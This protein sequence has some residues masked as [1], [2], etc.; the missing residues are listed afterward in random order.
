MPRL[1]AF[2]ELGRNQGASDVHL[3]VG[4]PPMVRVL[5]AMKPVKYR[6]LDRDELESLVDEILTDE[7]RRIFSDG[8][9]IDFSYA[10]PDVGRFRANVY[11]KLSGVGATF[12]VIPHQM[13]T[14]DDLGHPPVLKRLTEHSHGM[15]LVTGATGTGKTTTLAAMIN[16]MN[17]T[18]R[19]NIITLEDPVEFLH[20]SKQSL[21]VQREIGTSAASFQ[22][23]LRAA[24][25][26]DPDVILVGELRDPETIS[27]AMTAAETGH[28]VL[29][30]LH[31]TTATKTID[32]IIDVMPTEMK[33][34]AQVFLSQHLRGVVSQRL[35]RTA[36]KNSRRAVLEIMLN[37]PAIGNLIL[38]G[39]VFQIPSQIQTGRDKGMQLMDQTLMQAIL[40][41]ELDPDDAYLN[42]DDK[43]QFQRFVTDPDLLPQVSL[44]GV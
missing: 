38:N 32:R 36:D 22:D 40:N 8:N 1:N 5:G 25:R 12:R 6:A 23:G 28:L 2:L 14:L 37:S 3:A 24:L 20:E 7:Q 44:A 43:K 10:D 39:K 27:M 30:T 41:K 26:E 35:V 33:Q 42:A 34:Q 16:H 11:R 29:G 31:T 21:V 18:R 4:V 17:I 15:V 13:P 19:L 9:D